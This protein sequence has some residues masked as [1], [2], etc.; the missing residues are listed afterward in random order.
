MVDRL[1]SRKGDA[2]MSMILGFSGTSQGMAP[3][4]AKA[5]RQ[6]LYDCTEL[7]LGDCI[8]AD[9]EAY[10]IAGE[11]GIIRIGHP[12]RD[13]K[14]RAFLEYE[15][16]LPKQPYLVR[17]GH[18]ARDGVN[19]LIAAPQDWV[20]I[21]RGRDGGTWSTV[22]RARNYGRYIWIVRPDG[23]IIEE[24]GQNSDKSERQRWLHVKIWLSLIHI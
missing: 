14:K 21:K 19:G 15:R 12:P 7:H 9:A 8:G 6:L 16:E 4:Q 22:R 20:E 5:M 18:I 3:R 17:N 10:A 24:F 23:S 1:D 11:T 2:A 13:G